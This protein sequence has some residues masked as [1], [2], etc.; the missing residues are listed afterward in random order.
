MF[1]PSSGPGPSSTCCCSATG[2][3]AARCATTRRRCP[4]AAWASSTSLRCRAGT[5]LRRHPRPAQWPRAVGAR[6]QR[7]RWPAAWS[8]WSAMPSAADPTSCAA[9]ARSSPPATSAALAAALARV[10]RDV[11]GR[12]ALLRGRLA[13]F[14]IADDGGRVR[15]GGYRARAPRQGSAQPA[16]RAAGEGR[17]DDREPEQDHARNAGEQRGAVRS[18]LHDVGKQQDDQERAVHA[19]AQVGRLVEDPDQ[20]AEQEHPGISGNQPPCRYRS[21]SGVTLDE[22]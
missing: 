9:S 19:T 7:G 4:S 3:C 20:A 1:V 18:G 10:A 22:V 17:R 5:A 21:P 14:T 12:R 11:P 8:Q 6:R 2:R 16:G 15:A 13:R